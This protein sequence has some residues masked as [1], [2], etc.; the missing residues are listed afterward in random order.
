MSIGDYKKQKGAAA[1][2]FAI[3]MIPFIILIFAIFQFGIV[4]NNWI[5]LTHAAREGARLAAVAEDEIFIREE[6]VNRAP[7]VR[8]DKIDIDGLHGKVGNPVTVAVTG[9]M[10]N[11]DIPFIT[12]RSILLTS[13]ATLR[14]EK[15]L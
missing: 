12:S 8:I 1:V 15:E 6:I 9:E 14:I 7:S 3:I 10:I 2:E 11:L 5:A 4:F 13:S